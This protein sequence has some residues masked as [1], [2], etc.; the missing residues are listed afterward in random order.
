M[1]GAYFMD[2]L[3]ILY[4]KIYNTW[5]FLVAFVLHV[6][7]FY[8]TLGNLKF[9][10]RSSIRSI[11]LI[12]VAKTSDIREFGI[13][14]LIMAFISGVNEL[15]K[16]LLFYVI[17]FRNTVLV[18]GV[19]CNCIIVHRLEL[20][21]TKQSMIKDNQLHMLPRILCWAHKGAWVGRAN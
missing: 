1:F 11:E 3:W 9:S 21:C 20:V 15:A 19:A 16:V 8:Y 13:E 6:G 12:A 2:R 10:Y 7:L 17:V 4:I 18:M 5:I 14:K